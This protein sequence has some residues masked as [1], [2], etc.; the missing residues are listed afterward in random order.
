MI[1]GGFFNYADGSGVDPATL[2]FSGSMVLATGGS[3]FINNGVL[4]KA[5]TQGGSA[6]QLN[7]AQGDQ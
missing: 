3:R 2:G 4:N 1:N 5:T 7:D 6:L